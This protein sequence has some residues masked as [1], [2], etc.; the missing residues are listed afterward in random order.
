MKDL[1]EKYNMRKIDAAARMKLTPAA[2]TQYLKGKRGAVLI[3]EIEKSGE[4]M[5][6]LSELSKAVV[7]NSVPEELVIEKL[8]R[9]C[10]TLRG[11]GIC[12]CASLKA[13]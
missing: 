11:K 7:K 9:A 4:T 10:M 12:A 6:I 13:K 3:E 2:I 5:E 1:M 8:C